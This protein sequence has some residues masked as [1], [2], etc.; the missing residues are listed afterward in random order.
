MAH[1]S[2]M[3]TPYQILRKALEE[4]TQARDSYAK[5]ASAC[6]F[7]PVRELLEK[8][9]DEESKHVHMIKDLLEKLESG[10]TLV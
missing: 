2:P 10:R 8:L 7:D 9:R 3:T 1:P 5:L 4:E 6:S